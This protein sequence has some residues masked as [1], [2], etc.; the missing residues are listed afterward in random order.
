MV[1][2]PL[3]RRRLL[4]GAVGLAGADAAVP[5]AASDPELSV[6]TRNL[7]VGVDLFRLFV[8]EDR[9]E[10]RAH[11]FAAR[12]DAVAAGIARADPDVVCL[13]EAA[14]VRTRA[15]SR[16]DG[17]HDPSVTPGSRSGPRSTA[18]PSGCGRRTTRASSRRSRFLR[19]T[20]AHRPSRGR[21]RRPRPRPVGG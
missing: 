13:Q 20:R 1:P 4:R 8:V 14:L 3:S 6:M 5:A 21:R 10:L 17:D 2:P 19:R 7:Y 18:S 9:R 11:L 16:F 15:P 12:L